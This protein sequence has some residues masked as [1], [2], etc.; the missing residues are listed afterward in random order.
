MIG[1]Q[2]TP[3]LVLRILVLPK[4]TEIHVIIL[5]RWI[6]INDSLYLENYAL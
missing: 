6:Q 2:A 4:L 3:R 5:A 1:S